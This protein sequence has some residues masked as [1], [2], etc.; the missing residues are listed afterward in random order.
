MKSKLFT[1]SITLLLAFAQASP[2]F[3]QT[4]GGGGNWS[5]VGELSRGDKLSV[6]MKSGERVEGKLSSVSDAALVISQDGSKTATLE[7]ADI[8]RVYHTRGSSRRKWALIGTAIGGGVGAGG[9]GYLIARGVS[10][11]A[12]IVG[13][14]ALGAG[15]GAGLGAALGRD[16]KNDL[17]YEA[18]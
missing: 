16:K 8:R 15:I 1:L 5:A 4:T 3:A 9:G 7:R 12:V 6:E 13:G 10:E 11:P 18:R 17:I 14:A 2:A